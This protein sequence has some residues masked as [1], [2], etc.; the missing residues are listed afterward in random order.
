MAV[1]EMVQQIVDRAVVCLKCFLRLTSTFVG[2]GI[3]QVCLACLVMWYT[4]GQIVII[5]E[6]CHDVILFEI[7]PAASEGY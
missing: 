1:L 6:L 7:L 3:L 4:V 5:R 2:L